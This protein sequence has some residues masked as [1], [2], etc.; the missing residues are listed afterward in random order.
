MELQ[1]RAAICACLYSRLDT[2]ARCDHQHHVQATIIPYA[3]SEYAFEF[4]L[5]I[6]SGVDA[7]VN[8]KQSEILKDVFVLSLWLMIVSLWDQLKCDKDVSGNLAAWTSIDSTCKYGIVRRTHVRGGV[9]H[10]GHLQD[11][12]H[13]ELSIINSL[14]SEQVLSRAHRAANSTLKVEVPACARAEVI[15]ILT[16]ADPAELVVMSAKFYSS[17]P[18]AAGLHKITLALSVGQDSAK[19]VA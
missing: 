18:V 17:A 15:D 10:F 16:Y 5:C 3:R 9:C 7:D 2:S 8:E 1:N 11:L 19:F 14:C 4:L 12:Y 6:L 13:G